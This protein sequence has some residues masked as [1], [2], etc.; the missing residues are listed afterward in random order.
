[1]K[2]AIPLAAAAALLVTTTVASANTFA[3]TVTNKT[4]S[5]V[6]AFYASPKGVKAWEEDLL[7]D[8][9]LG[10]GESITIRF[11]DSRDV[12]EY[13]L[14]VEFYEDDLEDMTDTQNLCEIGEYEI[15]E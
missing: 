10:A 7:N 5:V 15:Y 4:N 3:L 13:D 12:C 2:T 6:D 8:K 11:S 14:L 9:V 1:M